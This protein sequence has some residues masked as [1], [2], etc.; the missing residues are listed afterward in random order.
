M[1]EQLGYYTFEDITEADPY[2]DDDVATYYDE[3]ANG[4]KL[5]RL[6]YSSAS[7][8]QG[9]FFL[10]LSGEYTMVSS[11]PYGNEWLMFA[12]M[13]DGTAMISMEGY[14]GAGAMGDKGSLVF[15]GPDNSI[16]ARIVCIRN[17]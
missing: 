7:M 12:D 14:G 11:M 9:S 8:S 16:I 3:I 2:T 13:E 17:Y 15:Y 5:Y 4:S 6:T 10:T 1:Y